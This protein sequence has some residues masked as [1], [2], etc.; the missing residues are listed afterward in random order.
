MAEL[1]LR[2]KQISPCIIRFCTLMTVTTYALFTG[3]SSLTDQ[4]TKTSDAR[5]L[6]SSVA[7]PHWVRSV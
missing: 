2:D 5:T 3:P 6:V 7:C 4:V 1:P